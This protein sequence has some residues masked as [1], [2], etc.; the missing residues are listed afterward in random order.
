M[1]TDERHGPDEYSSLTAAL[2]YEF[3]D[4]GLLRQ[5]LT[6]RSRANEW[7]AENEL[8]NERLE[9]IGDAVLDLSIARYLMESLPNARE[10]SLSKLRALVV[11]E[12]SLAR[13]AQALELGSYVRLGRGEE[14]TGGRNKASILADA[15][16][17][18]VGA[19]YLDGG[20]DVADSAVRAH[21]G[22][23][24]DA[25]LRGQ[26]E[27]DHKTRLQ[28]LTQ[29]RLRQVPQY[30]VIDHRGPDHAKIFEVA[31]SVEG[32]QIARAEG[33]SKKEAEQQA[34]RL[35]LGVLEEDH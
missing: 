34:A 10:G 18:V 6:H 31:V 19:I 7:G 32:R 8:H 35:A 3:I 24:V 2:G 9:F 23:L 27:P 12:A 17:A 14:Q 13:A 20:F 25:A 21:L 15:F 22:P 33:S 28:E 26:I 30:D 1:M 4:M 5:A 16:E 11:S 29:G